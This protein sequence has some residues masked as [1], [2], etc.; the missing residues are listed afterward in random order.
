MNWKPLEDLEV[1]NNNVINLFT[2]LLT[3]QLN[4]RTED[5]PPKLLTDYEHKIT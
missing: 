5:C 1:S 3:G 4:L 2:A